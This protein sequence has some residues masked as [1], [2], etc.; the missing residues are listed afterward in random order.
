MNPPLIVRSPPSGVNVC[1]LAAKECA[2]ASFQVFVL[3][4]HFLKVF[5]Y[6]SDLLATFTLVVQTFSGTIPIVESQASACAMGSSI[7]PVSLA[8]V[9]PSLTTSTVESVRL[10]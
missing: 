8:I 10:W 4:V 5:G 6:R 7:G 3:V 9:K 2:G 1:A